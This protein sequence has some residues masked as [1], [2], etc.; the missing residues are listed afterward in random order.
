MLAELQKKA[1]QLLTENASTLLTAGG[2]VGTVGTAILTGRASFKAAEIIREKE[3]D[4][5]ALELQK[6]E[7]AVH[8]MGLDKK[9]KVFLVWPL[10]LPPI[11]LGGVTIT[12]I[13]MAHRISAAK[14]AALAVAYGLIER[15]FEEYKEKALEKLGI[16]KEQK[17]RDEIAQDRVTNNPPDGQIVILAGGDVLCFDMLTGRYF[18]STVENIKKAENR[19]NT[20]MLNHDYASLTEF[21]EEIGL[22]PT[23]YTD[24]VGWNLARDGSLEVRFSTAMS[25]DDKP[26]ISVDF[27]TAPHPDY[28]QRY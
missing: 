4:E 25:T 22:P 16:G 23:S 7:P 6:D 14:A 17:L 19:L 3:V 20:A 12:S 26:C 2:V 5:L 15:D 9:T 21:Y 1:Q 27:N 8:T 13:V 11:G 18:R 28:I 24:E 10:F